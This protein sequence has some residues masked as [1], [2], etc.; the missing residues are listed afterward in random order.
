M[1]VL[2]PA[3]FVNRME[4]FPCKV[5]IIL[6]IIRLEVAKTVISGERR[7]AQRPSFF[8]FSVERLQINVIT[9]SR[10]K[11]VSHRNI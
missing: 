10:I 8:V 5:L 4:T 9:N 11:A 2:H 6:L 3:T 1:D 7:R